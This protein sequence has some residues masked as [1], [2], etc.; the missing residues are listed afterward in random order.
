[1][2]I[3]RFLLF[4]FEG[5]DPVIYGIA[6]IA[7]GYFAA[8]VVAEHRGQRRMN[9]NDLLRWQNNRLCSAI[10]THLQSPGCNAAAA[11]NPSAGLLVAVRATSS[12]MEK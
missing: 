2:S 7:I 6:G 9:E 8:M 1:M 3:Q 10:E 11:P 4:L 5:L 12:H